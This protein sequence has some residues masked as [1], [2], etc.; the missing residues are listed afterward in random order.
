MAS[1]TLN[2]SGPSPDPLSATSGEAITITNST[3]AAVV[4]TLSHAGLLN[5]SNGTTLNVPAAGWS[6][7]VGTTSGTFSYPDG[8]VKRGT[9][10]GTINVTK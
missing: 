10:S 3:G 8:G 5:P 1:I 4:L 9:R 6:G 7:T 2:T